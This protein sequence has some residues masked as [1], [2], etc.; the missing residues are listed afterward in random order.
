[1]NLT[2]KSIGRSLQNFIIEKLESK[3]GATFKKPFLSY[4]CTLEEK[5]RSGTFG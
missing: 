4:G 5:L 2:S 3:H 1:M